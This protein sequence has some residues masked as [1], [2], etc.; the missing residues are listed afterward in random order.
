MSEKLSLFASLRFSRHQ[1]PKRPSKQEFGSLYWIDQARPASIHRVH[2][3]GSAANGLPPYEAQRLVENGLSSPRALALSPHTG[4]MFLADSGTASLTSYAL[5]SGVHVQHLCSPAE[6]RG[7]AMRS[8]VD[9]EV[10]TSIAL[11]QSGAGAS[12]R[13]R[14][15]GGAALGL[16]L[17]VLSLS[18]AVV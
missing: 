4:L 6:P 10:G 17:V 13:R 3:N 5:E 11:S 15:L 7:L 12:G 9:A 2:L 14:R 8:D 16:V 1:D 18:S